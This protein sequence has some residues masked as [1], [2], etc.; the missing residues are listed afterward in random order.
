MAGRGCRE[1][2]LELVKGTKVFADGTL[3]VS[4]GLSS[5]LSVQAL[6]VEGV[7]PGLA[8]TVKDWS[9]ISSLFTM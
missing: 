5:S 1:L 4:G 3:D 8:C 6:P 7:V 9:S 2:V